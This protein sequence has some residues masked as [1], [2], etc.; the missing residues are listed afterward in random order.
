MRD[1]LASEG[2]PSLKAALADN[3]AFLLEFLD[4]GRTIDELVANLD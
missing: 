2:S 3:E 1:V 4:R